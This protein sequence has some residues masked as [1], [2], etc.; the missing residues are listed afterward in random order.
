MCIALLALGAD[1]L[2]SFV[3]GDVGAA[4]AGGSGGQKSASCALLLAVAR[5]FDR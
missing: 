5:D 3:G 1:A 4:A 2:M